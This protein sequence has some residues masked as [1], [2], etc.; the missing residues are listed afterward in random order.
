MA[1]RRQHLQRFQSDC[2]SHDGEDN[3]QD[4][5]GVSESER[6]TYQRKCRETF[7]VRGGKHR[8]GV[9]RRQR[10]VDDEGECQ[11]ARN[12]RYPLNHGWQISYNQVDLNLLAAVQVG[13]ED[14]WLNIVNPRRS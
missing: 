11:P 1:I 10:R 2:G 12:N 13:S 4:A 14:D 8:T 9:D 5:A 6:K 7:K 3:K